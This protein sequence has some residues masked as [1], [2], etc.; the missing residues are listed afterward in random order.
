[1]NGRLSLRTGVSHA[2]LI[3]GLAVALSA[4]DHAPA[5]AQQAAPATQPAAQPAAGR[6]AA[7]TTPLP[8]VTVE[9]RTPANTLKHES[10]VNRLPGTV[11]DTPQAINVIPQEIMRQQGVSTL[12]QA[13]RNV[14]GVTVNIGE[15]GGGMNGDQF[16]IRGFEAKGDIY[17]D[18][19]RDFGV[20]TRDSFNYE[21]VQVLK[22]PTANAFGMGTTGGA[23]NTSS[24]TP[25]LGDLYSGIA[26]GGMGP[27]ARLTV[28]VN[29][30]V[31]DSIAFRVNGML[32]RNEL[33]DREEVGSKRWGIAPSIAFG[34]NTD[35]TFTLSYL[36]Q[37]DDR[38]P[39]YGVPVVTPTGR[40]KGKPVTEY[41]VNRKNW[42]GND[43]D[44]DDT[45]ID[46]LTGRFSH[47]AND[48]L[49]LYNDTRLAFYDRKFAA[50]PVSCNTACIDSYRAGGSPNVT[51]GGPGPF[52]QD[53]WGAQNISTAVAKFA[54]GFMRH[55]LVVGVDAFYQHDKR[56]SYAYRQLNGTSGR[57]GT[58]L[59][60]PDHSSVGYEII[61]STA[62]TA[63]R[64]S[65]SKNFAL[66]ASDRIWFT[67][68]ISVIGGLR[69]DK[70]WA[71]TETDGP[72][73]SPTKLKADSSRLN[74]KASLVF[75]PTE[76][77][78][79]YLSYATSTS[80]TGQFIASGP[81]PITAANEALKPERNKIYEAGAKIGLFDGR[82]GLT[83]SVFRVEKGNAK[84]LNEAGD[85][86]AS[87]DKQR[88]NGV[89]LG[90]TGRI[91][92][93]WS[94]SAN[95]TYLDSK[96]LDSATPDNEGKRVQQVPKH[97]ASIWTT[98]QVLPELL[99]GGGLTFRDSVYLNAANTA[100][101]PANVSFDAMVAYQL[102][103]NLTLGVN[104]YN[105]TNR[106]NYDSLYTNRVI[107]AAGRTII[108]SLGA[109]F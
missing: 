93:A 63:R 106:L 20:Y 36:H 60:N 74:P 104:G 1:M 9:D 66:F 48:W 69:W 31:S 79:Y 80:P 39:D 34:L 75:E 57:P 50:T 30:Q 82:L 59:T 18:G 84:E 94:V 90:A 54:T 108:V 61:P 43:T 73:D 47:K 55:E 71:E 23:I 85:I 83:A 11:Q 37:E 2:A 5:A 99:V 81:N 72:N 67:D 4:L 98:Y 78:T 107:P 13:L 46:I 33:V 91:T 6:P 28:D 19:L 76:N 86:V 26:S 100:K 105:L 49:T 27:Y 101:V 65:E 16:R 102:T 24:K 32:H 64:E 35:T 88:V 62:A 70:Y 92:D 12:D 10:S 95:Y 45:T 7:D 89:E 17:I 3:A 97:A 41:G 14:P 22:G 109:T 96:T 21:Q 52:K 77:Q 56:K 58:S 68:Q 15:G 40:S 51:R 42:Y 38:V 103:E 44:H 53:S 87:G 29:K 8:A 25:F